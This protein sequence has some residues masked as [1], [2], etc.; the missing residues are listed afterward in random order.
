MVSLV[1]D[2]ITNEPGFTETR[3]T[4]R[5]LKKNVEAIPIF[6]YHVY[7]ALMEEVFEM[8]YCAIFPCFRL[9]FR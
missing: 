3:S 9:R 2:F 5:E 8:T 6:S 1:S 4:R 7:F